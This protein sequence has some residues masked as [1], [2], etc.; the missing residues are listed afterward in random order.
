MTGRNKHVY[1]TIIHH[2]TL[3]CSTNRL[4]WH[5]GMIP[6]RE[7]WVKV[8][9]D[10]GADTVKIVFQLCNVIN[11]N[12]VIN[13]CVFCV[14]EGKDTTTNLHVALDRYKPDFEHLSAIR[15]RYT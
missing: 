11:P 6:E 15:W 13:T 3:T 8:G 14:F 1:T 10:K 5:N 2:C 9:G 7:V 12:S 4:T